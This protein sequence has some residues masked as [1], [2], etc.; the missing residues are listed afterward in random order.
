MVTRVAKRGGGRKELSSVGRPPKSLLTRVLE[1]SFRP[2]RYAHLLPAEPLP[3]RSP[4]RDERRRDLWQELR[5]IQ[6]QSLK[7]PEY[8]A[9]YA[10]DFSRLVRSL[11][12][13][14]PP[15]WYRERRERSRRRMHEL[16]AS[17]TPSEE[18]LAL[19]QACENARPA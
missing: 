8:L 19:I 17:Y 18:V 4:F 12:G 9:S 3:R 7:E 15:R 11:H 1:N 14:A 2:G 16:A 13:A 6:R 5:A 10:G